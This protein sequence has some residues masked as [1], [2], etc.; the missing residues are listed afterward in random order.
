V[1]NGESGVKDGNG[2]WRRC[3]RAPFMGQGGGKVADRGR[4]M[5][6]SSGGS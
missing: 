1:R 3:Y 4:L 2:L 6:S 5:E